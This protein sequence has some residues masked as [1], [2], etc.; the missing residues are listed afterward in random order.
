MAWRAP[1]FALVGRFAEGNL[2]NREEDL[3]VD[4]RLQFHQRILQFRQALQKEMFVKKAS[5]IDVTSW[6]RGK[7]I[8]FCHKLYGFLAI[9][10]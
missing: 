9:Y 10:G 3:P 1:Y 6:Q 7:W 8:M 4:M 5:W 2:K